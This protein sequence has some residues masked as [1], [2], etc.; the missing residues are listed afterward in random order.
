MSQD[1]KDLY[2]RGVAVE[3]GRRKR[4]ETVVSIRKAKKA[5]RLNQR[6]RLCRDQTVT[7]EDNLDC[8]HKLYDKNPQLILE[9]IRHYRKMLSN[10]KDPPVEEIISAG[11]TPRFVELLTYDKT[12]IV[13]FEA[14][15]ALTNIT[16][17][18]SEQTKHVVELGVVPYFI[19][20]LQSPNE[21]VRDQ[22]I[23]ALGNITGDSTT[24]RDLVL[25]S[26]AMRP[27][28]AQFQMS[29][30][31]SLL[32]NATWTLSNFCRGKPRP[33]FELVRMAIP[34]LTQLLYQQDDEILTD[35]C[36]ALSYMSD[37]ED[38]NIQ[39]V[40][41]SGVI[42]RLIELLGHPK[43][44][45]KT[46]ALRTIGN[47]ATGNDV[48]TQILLNHSLLPSLLPLMSHPK[49]NIR[50]ESCWTVSNITA[51]NNEQISNV[52]MS[53]LVPPLV[54]AMTHGE[55]DVKKEA[56]WAISNATVGATTEQ[57]QYLVDQECLQPLCDLLS[58]KDGSIVTVV[59]EALENILKTD[60]PYVPLVEAANG[61]DKLDDLQNHSN[62]M[63]YE[64]AVGLLEKYFGAVDEDT[65]ENVPAVSANGFFSFGN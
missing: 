55:F 2:K 39:C 40:V 42:T 3:D 10:E 48:Q 7:K 53:G 58:V 51:G 63:I 45:V 20:L 34:T 47:I 22:T 1:H 5:E 61:L 38:V 52:F 16:S 43:D 33:D 15:W 11:L 14:A 46:P 37:G 4:E 19:K 36:W 25:R 29:A 24:F 62:H 59:L 50:K 54:H 30:N 23:W 41:D 12:P 60:G 28:L 57:I 65:D 6:R 56:A 44:S 18:T 17:G 13:Q 49:R 35:A 32:H 9:G 27:M 8:R 64:K 31:P 21:N 26:G